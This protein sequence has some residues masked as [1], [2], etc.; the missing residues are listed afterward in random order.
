M[1]DP[2]IRFSFPRQPG[3]PHPPPEGNGVPKTMNNMH[4]ANRQ[5]WNE[6]AAE[7][8]KRRHD[9]S[10]IWQRCGNDP[11]LAFDC[12]FLGVAREFAPDLASKKICVVGSGNNFATFALASLG[13]KVTSIDQ[14]EKQL[15]IAA[16]R[17][18]TARIRFPDHKS[19]AHLGRNLARERSLDQVDEKRGDENRQESR[20]RRLAGRLGNRR[21]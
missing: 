2:T 16:G 4:E 1:S 9:E 5:H 19:K 8:F 7:D 12:D 17:A 10:G 21:E 11:D 13:A 3:R 6:S 20:S 14:S 18:E 15:E